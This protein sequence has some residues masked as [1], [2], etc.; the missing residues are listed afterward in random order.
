MELIKSY[1]Y[2]KHFEISVDKLKEMLLTDNYPRFYDF[3]KML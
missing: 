3:K 2:K 1:Q